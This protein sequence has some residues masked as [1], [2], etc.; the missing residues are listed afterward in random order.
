[1]VSTSSACACT[2]QNSAIRKMFDA[3][4]KNGDGTLDK[5]EF[6]SYM[7]SNAKSSLGG[8]G[9]VFADFFDQV[10]A[11]NDHMIDFNE[12]SKM[13]STAAQF[14]DDVS[15]SNC[16]DAGPAETNG[17]ATQAPV[18]NDTG[19][20]GQGQDQGEPQH[21]CQLKNPVSELGDTLA[22]IGLEPDDAH[23]MLVDQG[24]V[25]V[26]C[27]GT[28]TA[29]DKTARFLEQL[30]TLR[31]GSSEGVNEVLGK[32]IEWLV[33][34]GATWEG[35]TQFMFEHDAIKADAQGNIA[36]SYP[37]GLTLNHYLCQMMAPDFRASEQA[38]NEA[39]DLGLGTIYD[40]KTAA[41]QDPIETLNWMLDS[42]LAEITD[43]GVIAP[44]AKSALFTSQL[45]A[46]AK[47]NHEGVDPTLCRAFDEMTNADGCPQDFMNFLFESDMMTMDADGK[48]ILNEKGSGFSH[49]F[50]QLADLDFRATQVNEA[51]PVDAELAQIYDGLRAQERD[52]MN[53]IRYLIEHD[54][55]Q[56]STTG[57][58]DQTDSTDPTA[59]ILKDFKAIA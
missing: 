38:G 10:D 42:G 37:K 55:A 8:A 22:D 1:M 19:G 41:G 35:A 20:Q 7:Q 45:D 25:D 54:L 26:D 3:A 56:M 5:G 34:D 18:K 30:Q 31:G 58:L 29:N 9:T 16:S 17:A 36:F 33:D 46:L 14:A 32:R 11:N 48:P 23:K 43:R 15:G 13:A 50:L 6:Q 57:S 47:G 39:L 21:T 24:L 27:Q 40:K 53:A 44:T 4:D 59:H 12:F 52:P 51:D 2:S 28:M 49:D